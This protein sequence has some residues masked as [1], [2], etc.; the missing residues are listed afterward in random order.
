MQD[1][2][3]PVVNNEDWHAE[4]KKL[5]QNY[6]SQ[7]S[8][9]SGLLESLLS[10]G[11]QGRGPA[12]V[13]EDRFN[14]AISFLALDDETKKAAL[15]LLVDYL[16]GFALAVHYSGDDLKP[17][18]NDIALPLDLYLSALELASRQNIGMESR[19]G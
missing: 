8:S 4:L 12:E 7:L 6:V 15:D 2:Y 18:I 5:C 1:I 3:I 16:H 14:I 9:H 11:P 13:F 17:E 19:A 10:M